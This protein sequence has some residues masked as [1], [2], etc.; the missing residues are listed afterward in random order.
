MGSPR[1]GCPFF[2]SAIT[3]AVNGERLAGPGVYFIIES[4]LNGI[5]TLMQ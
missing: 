2:C 1:M 3:E 4:V 5:P